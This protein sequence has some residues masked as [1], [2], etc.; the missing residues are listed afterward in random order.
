ME[1]G[2]PTRAREL[3]LWPEMPVTVVV[4]GPHAGDFL[5]AVLQHHS[6]LQQ[7]LQGVGANQPAGRSRIH[8]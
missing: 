3:S 5:L 6:S 1:K 2:K 4:L 8:K 7:L